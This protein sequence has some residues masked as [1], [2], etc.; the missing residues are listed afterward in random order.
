MALGHQLRQRGVSGD[1]I[2]LV[3]RHATD[4][5]IARAFHHQQRDRPFGARLQNQQAIELQRPH[6]QGGGSHQFAEQRLHRLWVFMT[7]QHRGIAVI[8]RHPLAAHI[9]L[10]EDETLGEIGI[11]QIAH[12][13]WLSKK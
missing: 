8:E 9:A 1:L 6:Q 7:R 3:A 13:F 2:G 12:R 5:A 4:V 10:V 11:R